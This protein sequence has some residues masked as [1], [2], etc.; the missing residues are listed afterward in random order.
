MADTS[1]IPKPGQ[2]VVLRDRPGVVE[3]VSAS[4]GASD[5]KYHCI[6]TRYIDGWFYPRE[7]TVIWEHEPHARVLEGQRWPHIEAKRPDRIEPFEAF[8]DAYRWSATNK[9][10]D[11]SPG[12]NEGHHLV[13]PWYNAVQI[14]DYQLYPLLKS[15]LMPRVCLLLADDVGLGK[16]IEAG[17]IMSELL[18][19][20][21]IRRVMVVC[22]ASLQKQWQEE[23]R[24]KFHMD[25]TVVDRDR[26][27]QL[28]RN[29]G[30]DTNP[31][32]TFPHIITSQ[33]YLRQHDVLASYRA[34][35][36]QMGNSRG[37]KL[38]W[39]LLIVDEAHN[40]APNRYGDDS[41]RCRMLRE[42][43]K[44]FQH[45]L[46]LTATPHDGYTLSFTGL[47]EMLDPVRFHQKATLDS[48]DHEQKKVVMVRRLKSE[49]TENGRTDRFARRKPP[50]SLELDL[51]SAEKKLYSALRQYREQLSEVLRRDDKQKRHIGNFLS[52]LLTKR[53]L[54]SPCAFAWTWWQHVEG[55]GLEDVSSAQAE[56]ARNR[57]EASIEDDREKDQRD[58]DAARQC[59]GWLTRHAA[60]L[61]DERE[62]VGKAL[63]EL[64][65]DPERMKE[66][67]LATDEIPGSA[68]WKKLKGW[69]SD[70]LVVDGKLRDDE[71]LIIFTEYKHTLDYVTARLRKAGF[72]SPQVETL[73]GGA[74]TEHR[75]KIKQA[76]N[77]PESPLRI[78]V[79]TDTA[80]EGINLQTSCRYVIHYE[81]P[82]N[83]MRLEQRNGRVDRHGQSREVYVH[84]FTSNEETDLNF[85]SRVVNKV[86]QV[87]EDLGSVG[88][89]IDNAVIEHF[90]DSQIGGGELDRRIEAMPDRRTDEEDLQ[91]TDRGSEADYDK[92]FQQLRATEMALGL[93][94][95]RLARL[96]QTAMALEDGKLVETENAGIYEIKEAPPEWKKLIRET[97]E[98]RSGDLEGQRPKLVF[99]PARLE[100]EVNG[101]RVLRERPDVTLI[102]LGHPLMQRAMGVLQRCLWEEGSPRR[103]TMVGAPLPPG[104]DRIL[105]LNMLLE[106][107]NELRETVHE[108]VL[109]APFRIK[110]KGLTEL[111]SSLWQQIDELSLHPLAGEKLSQQKGS[112]RTDWPFHREFLQDYIRSEK[113]RLEEEF[114]NRLGNMKERKIQ[115]AKER[116]ASRLH[117]LG[118]RDKKQTVSK[119]REELEEKR[120]DLQQKKLWKDKERQLKREIRELEWE[121][122]H[123]HIES[124]RRLV[125]KE[126]DRMIDEILPSRYSLS[127]LNLHP[128]AVQYIV[129]DNNGL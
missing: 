62:E 93:E 64:G 95:G 27:F 39:D 41:D 38:P 44:D 11:R 37:G 51:S 126:K 75:E 100:E 72:G 102:R 13:S 24:D 96:L 48:T 5:T 69:I 127:S 18:V 88:K 35:T 109:A 56:Y 58:Q 30:M 28:Q 31:W 103:W 83:P 17:L 53:L 42:I 2:A 116:F 74:S 104:V 105:V 78:L 49:L 7:D 84:H 85:L 8:I 125:R 60:G 101:R 117:E 68:K 1:E 108:D 52:Q 112:I 76:F 107:T 29:L 120:R 43:S 79:A 94:E 26:T 124:L 23:M 33:D 4:Q 34:A 81:I 65:W 32:S 129:R 90:T 46:F 99:D 86:E 67:P 121:V 92:A 89:V 98:Y 110:G 115:E 47:L 54:S 128:L 10:R 80:A 106:V 63:R 122:H 14:E 59:G 55:I 25:F 111:D 50:R 9:L 36:D 119:L 97:L 87:R 22:P 71:R 113:S 61:E 114:R 70:H 3:D 15:L 57:A 20:R 45:R 118:Q 16:T 82:W 6:T 12:G 73:F 21:R 91:D 40:F 66:G 123:S 77:D 19:R